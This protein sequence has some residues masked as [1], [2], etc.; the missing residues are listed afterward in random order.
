MAGGVGAPWPRARPPLTAAVCSSARACS[1]RCGVPV[2]L[3]LQA[4]AVVVGWCR[5]LRRQRWIGQL[6]GRFFSVRSGWEDSP[7]S[8]YLRNGEETPRLGHNQLRHRRCS[9]Q[10]SPSIPTCGAACTATVGFHAAQGIAVRHALLPAPSGDAGQQPH[11]LA[12]PHVHGRSRHD[13]RPRSA[14]RSPQARVGLGLLS[15]E[16]CLHALPAGARA[17]GGGRAAGLQPTPT[18]SAVTAV[19]TIHLRRECSDATPND[20]ARHRGLRPR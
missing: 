10:R 11:L 12:A 15:P 6:V 8:I 19:V 1:P 4:R 20:P 9:A 17:H 14:H 13:G 3:C 18:T 16:A 7:G 5:Q 2:Y